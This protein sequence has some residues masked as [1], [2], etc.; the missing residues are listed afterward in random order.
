[1]ENLEQKLSSEE[2]KKIESTD[3]DVASYLGVQPLGSSFHEPA[4]KLCGEYERG[5]EERKTISLLE[6][7]RDV[8]AEVAARFQYLS[9]HEKDAEEYLKK[10]EGKS[11]EEEV[12]KCMEDYQK[13]V[14]MVSGIFSYLMSIVKSEKAREYVKQ[15][16]ETPNDLR[17]IVL[18]VYKSCKSEDELK[19]TCKKILTSKPEDAYSSIVSLFKQ[20][21]QEEK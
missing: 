20:E 18:S 21:K 17:G 13:I 2:I 5:K 10:I 9:L 4:Y 12:K 11:E 19:E 6:E 15:I 8:Y 7:S 3:E 16:K 1:M 14:D